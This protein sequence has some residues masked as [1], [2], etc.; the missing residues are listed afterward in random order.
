[1]LIPVDAAKGLNSL[2]TLRA[3]E[4]GAAIAAGATTGMRAGIAGVSVRDVE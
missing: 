4:A 1:M 3:G 2:T